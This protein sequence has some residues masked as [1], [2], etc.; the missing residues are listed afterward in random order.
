MSHRVFI[1]VLAVVFGLPV[2]AVAQSR[3]IRGIMGREAPSWR[4]DQWF[5]LPE[6]AESIDVQDYRGKVIYFYG[7]QSWCPG[8]HSRGFP[9]LQELI[10]RFEGAED[11]AFVAVQTTFEGFSFNTL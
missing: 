2:H 4:V 9:T 8:C 3:G 10:R 11:V 5:Q 6:G 7:F 1:V